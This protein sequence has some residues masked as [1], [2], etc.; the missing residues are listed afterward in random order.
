[1]TNHTFIASPVSVLTGDAARAALETTN[2]AAH[3]TEGKGVLSVPLERWKY[4]QGYEAYTWLTQGL[5]LTE[6]RNTEHAAMF[7]GY[8]ALPENL[9]HVIELGCGPF[10]NM[11]HII[12][13]RQ[14]QSI[15]LLDPLISSYANHP[16]CTYTFSEKRTIP[17]TGALMGRDV[18]IIPLAIESFN[19]RYLYGQISIGEYDTVIMVNV[20]SHCLDASKVFAWFEKRLKRGGILVFHEPARDIDVHTH[21]DIGHPLS[22]TQEVIDDFL[23]DYEIVY[24]NGDYV[25]GTKK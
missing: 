11:V 24:K 23:S 15:T 3:Y 6:D 25:I 4:A 12:P 9:G 14:A 18:E 2:D 16:H 19:I 1:M 8:K 5:M 7:D 13:E 20:L 10:T 22:Y 17:M 21:W